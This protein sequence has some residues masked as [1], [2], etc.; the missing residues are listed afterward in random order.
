MPCVAT[1]GEQRN[2]SGAAALAPNTPARREQTYSKCEQ[3]ML[4]IVEHENLEKALTR[5]EKNKGAAG[6]DKM[7]VENLREYLKLHWAEIKEKLQNGTY[8]PQPVRRV[9]IA[10]PGG[11]V[12]KLGIPT[13]VDRCIQQAIHQVLSPIF[14]VTFSNNGKCQDRCR[15]ES[16]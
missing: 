16:T 8:Q 13:V 5:V 15:V 12:R 7:P 14:D 4:A 3:L 1:A 6:V 10:K 2:C 9:E 11:G